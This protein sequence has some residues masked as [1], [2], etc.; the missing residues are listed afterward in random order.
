[1]RPR[2]CY[3]SARKR[4]T[5]WANDSRNLNTALDSGRPYICRE[6]APGVE[7]SECHCLPRTPCS[8][9]ICSTRPEIL[10]RCHLS[11][12]PQL[13][14][15]AQEQCQDQAKAML[16]PRG[17]QS[18]GNR[19]RS[20]LLGCKAPSQAAQPRSK[21]RC[22]VADVERAALDSG[23][24]RVTGFHSYAHN[25]QQKLKMHRQGATVPSTGTKMGSRKAIREFASVTSLQVH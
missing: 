21:L 12:G 2:C 17:S 5:E 8:G 16:S 24:K 10:P 14:G 25:R 23:S 11:A 4:R 22:K 6:P 20:S 18:S 3:L 7:R 15:G 19:P 1:M 13:A 9:P